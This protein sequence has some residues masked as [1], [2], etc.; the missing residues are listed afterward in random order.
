MTRS[1][2]KDIFLTN[3]EYSTIIKVIDK[4]Y[5]DFE[6]RTC[7]NCRSYQDNQV[8][9]NDTS[10]LCCDFVS[11]DYGCNLWEKIDD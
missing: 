3:R 10:P 5:D 4:I 6:L 9:T 1:K 2:A 8:C 7:K 11:S